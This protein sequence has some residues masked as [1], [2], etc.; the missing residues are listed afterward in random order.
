MNVVTNTPVRAN[1]LAREKSPYLLQHQYNPVDWHA[2]GPEAFERARREGKPIFLSIGY[3]TCHWCHVM[4]RESFENKPVADFL[5]EHFISIK[6]DREERP[7]VD[8]I[9]LAFV[10]AMGQQGG[11]PLNVFLTPELKPFYGGTYWPPEPRFERP[12]FLQVL[13]QVS[14][15]WEARREQLEHS[16]AGLHERLAEL[17]TWDSAPEA[18]LNKEVIHRAGGA[19]K[20]NFDPQFGGWGTAPK[21][22]SPSLLS[23]MLLYGREFEDREAVNMVL[24][25]CERMAAGG[26]YDQ[27]GGGFHRYSVDQQWLVPHF[28]KMLYDNAQL[29][30]L[31]LDCHLVS[32]NPSFA[33][34]AR[35]IL[36]YVLRDMTDPNGG[37]YSA[38]DADSEGKEGKFYT[39]TREEL[40]ALLAPEEFAIVERYYG[41]TE[42]G[43]FIDHSD[44]EP[45]PC[46][47]VLSIVD[48]RLEADEAPL[49]QSAKAKMFTARALRVRPHRDDKALASWNGLMLGALARAG[50]VLGEETHRAAAEK[51]LAFIQKRLWDSATKTLYHRWR[52]GERDQVQ[53]LPAY[54]FLLGGVLELYQATLAPQHLEFAVALAEGMLARFYDPDLGGF[55]Q[56]AGADGDLI[57]RI[58]EDY[59]GAEPAGNSA[60]IL[61]LAKLAALTGRPEFKAAAEKSLALFAPR[62]EQHPQAVP[63]MLQGLDFGLE[64]PR[65][66]VIAGDAASPPAQELL[67]AAHAV[68]QPRQVVLGTAGPVEPFA[69]T[70]PP[71]NGQATAYVCTGTACRPPTQKPAKVRELLMS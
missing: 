16:A 1:R 54:A 6:V 21:F 60:A 42:A 18:S 49:F 47:N 20:E 4:E 51:N 3:S 40:A 7:D 59:D 8:R 55:W 25:T 56:S 30:A 12:A 48:P 41:I 66:V 13:Q 34:T 65:R 27:L 44:P 52:D 67:R 61:A 37:F 14:K 36:S 28:E 23:F 46:Q 50:A 70:L 29:A 19:L 69:Q 43:N 33:E 58:K 62:L 24:R 63:Y 57:I 68:Y 2:W 64:E 39:W 5:N 26:I 15:A 45:L 9:Y 32:G 22:P 31:Y 53:L 38:E 11:W 35:D 17:I 71:K 10:Q